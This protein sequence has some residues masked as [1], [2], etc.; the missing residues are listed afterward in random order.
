[1]IG[2]VLLLV[3]PLSIDVWPLCSLA[4]EPNDSTPMV[5]GSDGRQWRPPPPPP[6]AHA[7]GVPQQTPMESYQPTWQMTDA[8]GASP[9]SPQGAPVQ[10]AYQ[11]H[12]VPLPSYPVTA[13]QGQ[14]VQPQA[15]QAPW[16]PHQESTLGRIVG[17][18][19]QV[20]YHHQIAGNANQHALHAGPGGH[21]RPG[22][23]AQVRRPPPP[24]QVQDARSFQHTQP[25]PQDHRPQRPIQLIKP[26]QYHEPYRSQA[27]PA[28]LQ[29][30]HFHAIPDTQYPMIST[31]PGAPHRPQAQPV[32][33]RPGRSLPPAN[34]Q[35]HDQVPPEQIPY[36]GHL[37]YET[38]P[39]DNIQHQGAPQSEHPAHQLPVQQEDTGR[40]VIHNPMPS[41]DAHHLMPQRQQAAQPHQEAA[42][43][44][45]HH[46]GV[47]S[48]HL[49]GQVHQQDQHSGPL[50]GQ[51]V[52]PQVSHQN[53][54][55]SD[56]K[57]PDVQPPGDQINAHHQDF[58]PAPALTQTSS[59]PSTS[60][61]DLTQFVSCVTNMFNRLCPRCINPR[62]DL[63]NVMKAEVNSSVTPDDAPQDTEA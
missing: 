4:P 2:N 55:N 34:V 59:T 42:P 26:P 52:M 13:Q 18:Q 28:Q 16:Q 50:S 44:V 39:Y 29:G 11:A 10:L 36:Q 57:V 40:A 22:L 41:L 54:A 25:R 23:P 17:P 20:Q 12:E 51:T 24:P 45:P 21:E 47:P 27:P 7:H 33:P 53:V 8:H 6:P 58:L 1:M 35:H 43:A 37:H 62:P 30:Q 3:L 46:H 38:N 19:D 31:N 49:R 14:Y 15:V 9:D 48:E 63:L 32:P 60:M 56:Q 5:P 61:Q